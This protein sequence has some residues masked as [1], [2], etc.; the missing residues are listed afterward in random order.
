MTMFSITTDDQ[1]RHTR[2]ALRTFLLNNFAT[3]DEVWELSSTRTLMIGDGNDLDEDDQ[4][5]A[6][7]LGTV[8]EYAASLDDA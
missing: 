8:A 5:D 1:R 2:T 4:A 7:L 6:V 3:D